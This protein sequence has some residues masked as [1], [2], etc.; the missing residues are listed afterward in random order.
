MG[1]V[2]TYVALPTDTNIVITI[3]GT[4]CCGLVRTDHFTLR[5]KPVP[6]DFTMSV[7]PTEDTIPQGRTTAPVITVDHTAGPA[8]PVSLIYALPADT[9]GID[10][11]IA[12]VS[13]TGDFSPTMTITANSVALPVDT[14][15]PINITATGG[16]LE[17]TATFN[18]TVTPLPFDF[19]MTLAPDAA[20]IGQGE[21]TTAIVTTTFKAGVV[22]EV[23]I[24]AA[25]PAGIT[26]NIDPSVVTPVVAPGLDSTMTIT[27]ALYAEVGKHRIIVT[28][29]SAGTVVE[30]ASFTLSVTMRA[31]PIELKEG[32][33]LISLPLIPEDSRIEVVLADILA[34]VISVHHFCAYADY[35]GL[36]AWKF[37]S[38]GIGG[39]LTDMIDGKG[40]WIYMKA[41]ATLTVIGT[42]MP[43]GAAVMPPA[44][45]L[46]VGWNHI[47]FKSV[48][49]MLVETY[50]GETVMATV[51][52]MWG[53]D[54]RTDIWFPIDRG[55]Y[56]QPGMGYWIAVSAPGTIFPAGEE[57]LE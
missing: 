44:Y 26:V 34:D 12:P 42:E 4:S 29:T 52:R 20:A 16:G 21:S 7:Y 27:A 49:P 38:P 3:I 17:R 50:L 5:I 10:V 31:F 30:T 15:I 41:A 45:D 40:Y 53:F 37:F 9:H 24:A 28:A 8:V 54:A 14:V 35:H 18:L 22:E 56:L 19:S 43:D 55:E 13:G 32:W 48:T 33:N 36:P 46:K 25:A 23:T 57:D 2:A 6:F 11:T 39:S 51:E 47:G 1:V